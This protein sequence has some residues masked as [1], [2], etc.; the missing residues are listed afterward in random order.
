MFLVEE[1]TKEE[2][3]CSCHGS[4][5]DPLKKNGPK[6]YCHINFPPLRS[7]GLD[8]IRPGL[9]MEELGSNP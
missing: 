1:F 7:F 8:G 6:L 3:E 9:Q 5:L 2:N 4:T